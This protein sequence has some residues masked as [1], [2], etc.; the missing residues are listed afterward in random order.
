MVYTHGLTL[1][2]RNLFILNAKKFND[3]IL[4]VKRITKF[5]DS[6][7]RIKV[8]T[9][10]FN[11]EKFKEV[12]ENALSGVKISYHRYSKWNH[13]VSFRHLKQN[14]IFNNTSNDIKTVNLSSTNLV[15]VINGNHELI[16]PNIPN[17]N[18]QNPFSHLT[19]ESF[20]FV[21]V[22]IPTDE[23]L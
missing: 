18:S 9:S 14:L 2:R 19:Q 22:G 15:N 21:L 8:Y 17:L 13:K 12:F 6:F 5:N 4:S 23:I 7:F 20:L 11:L 16:T 1:K 3:N 10:N